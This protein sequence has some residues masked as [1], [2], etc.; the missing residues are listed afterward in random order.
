MTIFWIFISNS[1]LSCFLVANPGRIS[2]SD[3]TSQDLSCHFPWR[4][5]FK[6]DTRTFYHRRSHA[7]TEKALRSLLSFEAASEVATDRQT[8]S[9]EERPRRGGHISRTD[10]PTTDCSRRR[11]L[12]GPAKM[13]RNVVVVPKIFIKMEWS[14]L[15]RMRPLRRRH[16]A[17]VALVFA[18]SAAARCDG[19]DLRYSRQISGGGQGEWMLI[20]MKY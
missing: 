5:A 16:A 12:Q 18:A 14:E 19:V 7:P 20:L 1:Q 9:L 11:V 17:A 3:P 6:P 8:L 4:H 15:L 2:L 10:R 13:S